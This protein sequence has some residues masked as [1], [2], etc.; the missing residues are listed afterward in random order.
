M[1]LAT[2]EATEAPRIPR[3]DATVVELR[4][5]PAID[6]GEYPVNLEMVKDA[7][8]TVERWQKYI[9]ANERLKEVVARLK[10][11]STLIGRAKKALDDREDEIRID[12]AYEDRIAGKNEAERKAKLAKVLREDAGYKAT[13]AELLSLEDERDALAAEQ[14]GLE[15]DVKLYQTVGAEVVALLQFSAIA[16]VAPRA[17]Q[18]FLG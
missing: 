18:G 10:S 4:L 12:A 1:T 2:H 11:L 6:P 3:L 7:F 9:N 17:A 8:Q 15:R 13:S 14:D 5:G 16:A